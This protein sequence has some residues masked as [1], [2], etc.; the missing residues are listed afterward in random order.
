MSLIFSAMARIFFA[1]MLAVSL[2][3][4]FRGHNEPGGGFVGGLVAASAFTMLALAENVSVARRA[5]HLHPV[6]LMGAGLLLAFFSGLPGVL[7]D[8]SFLAHWWFEVGSLHL[9]TATLF[10]IGVYCVVV[11]GVLCLI[12]RLYEDPAQ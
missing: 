3:L 7:S 8:R 1:L 5:L 11:G 6:V 10:D 12:F 4:L 2:F 9:G